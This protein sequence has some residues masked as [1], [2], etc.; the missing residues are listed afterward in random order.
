MA[1]RG[2]TS[3]RRRCW[4]V[5]RLGRH[6]CL[7]AAMDSAGRVASRGG[8]LLDEQCAMRAASAGTHTS[9]TDAVSGAG[10]VMEGQATDA[11]WRVARASA[12][13]DCRDA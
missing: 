5:G 4:L 13:R 12:H 9:R 2:L 6:R 1:R 3:G 10:L 11:S 7:P 8:W